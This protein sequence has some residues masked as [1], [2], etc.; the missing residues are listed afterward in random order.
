[1]ISPRIQFNC[2]IAMII[3]LSN[4]SCHINTSPSWLIILLKI[5]NTNKHRK[6][7][8]K[9]SVGHPPPRPP[10]IHR[11]CRPGNSSSR[12][13]KSCSSRLPGRKTRKD[14][15]RANRS[16]LFR[17]ASVGEIFFVESKDGWNTHHN[18]EV[19]CWSTPEGL[20]GWMWC[21]NHS[22]PEQ[23]RSSPNVDEVEEKELLCWLKLANQIIK[24]VY[25]YNYKYIY[26]YIYTY[27]HHA[28]CS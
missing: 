17:S 25:I 15:L 22:A 27:N 23:S 14:P 10:K 1:M 8:F 6:I 13:A 2:C 4:K 16:W 3:P 7:M 12:S 11:T 20:T 19:F 21:N 26:I 5:E 18:S 9:P 28:V 24:Y